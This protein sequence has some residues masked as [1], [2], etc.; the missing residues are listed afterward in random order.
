MAQKCTYQIEYKIESSTRC[1]FAI[2][3]GPGSYIRP[4]SAEIGKCNQN[5]KRHLIKLG[6]I[7]IIEEMLQDRDCVRKR[8]TKIE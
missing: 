6:H 7:N 2:E 5:L 4:V 8:A 1:P 3:E